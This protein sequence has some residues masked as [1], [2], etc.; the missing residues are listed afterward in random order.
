MPILNIKAPSVPVKYLVVNHAKDSGCLKANPAKSTVHTG[1]S[2]VRKSVVFKYMF[3][4]DDLDDCAT[5]ETGAG[6]LELAAAADIITSSLELCIFLRQFADRQWFR[7]VAMRVSV[8]RF[9][10]GVGGHK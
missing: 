10:F 7:G 1:K 3:H 8:Y 5:T 6:A 2:V 4:I 9:K